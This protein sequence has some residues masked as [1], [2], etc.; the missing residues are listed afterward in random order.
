MAYHVISA[1]KLAPDKFQTV[2]NKLIKNNMLDDRGK[3]TINGQLVVDEII[4]FEELAIAFPR[5]L[6]KLGLTFDGDLPR[7]KT[8]QRVDRRSAHEILS[9]KQKDQIYRSCHA[10]FEM[11]GYER[12]TL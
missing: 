11:L 10:T 7:A 12:Q 1:R 4:K 6:A 2:L 9:Q 8:H 3:Y 5:V